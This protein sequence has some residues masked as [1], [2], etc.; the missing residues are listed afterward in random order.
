MTTHQRA[1]PMWT[2]L[3]WVIPMVLMIGAC[4]GGGGPGPGPTAPTVS[5]T[6]PANGA[7]A[8]PVNTTIAITFSKAMAPAATENALSSVPAVVSD[9]VWNGAETTITCTPNANL[10]GA[11]LHTFTVGVAAISAD[12]RNLAA[13]YEFSFTTVAGGGDPAPPGTPSCVLGGPGL[14]GAC[15][16]GA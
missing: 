5:N 10:A 13:A 9:C 4:G 2:W 12:G 14:L 3:A 16:L 11:T 8:V 6:V 1:T 15:K 7:V